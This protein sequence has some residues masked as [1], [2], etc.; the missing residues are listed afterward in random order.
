MSKVLQSCGISAAKL[1]REGYNLFMGRG[2]HAEVI[3]HA[4]S[5]YMDGHL[6]HAVFEAAKAY[7][8]AV[9]EKA[10]SAKDGQS[11]MLEGLGLG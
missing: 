8:K 11:L 9:R 7:N 3:K 10:Q 6:F 4:Q 1:N 5:L 2:F